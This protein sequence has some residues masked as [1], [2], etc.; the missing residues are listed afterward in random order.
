MVRP[1]GS[2]GQAQTLLCTPAGRQGRRGLSYKFLKGFPHGTWGR[3][4]AVILVHHN[5]F[6]FLPNVSSLVTWFAE[7]VGPESREYYCW[8]RLLAFS[9]QKTQ[10][11]SVSELSIVSTGF[12]IAL[13]AVFPVYWFAPLYSLAP[14]EPSSVRYILLTSSTLMFFSSFLL[15]PL[16]L[17]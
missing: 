8:T 7:P 14:L 1:S 16:F 5:H 10:K 2:F 17:F 9:R 4:L 3:I 12:F 13:W 6:C 11:S 15:L